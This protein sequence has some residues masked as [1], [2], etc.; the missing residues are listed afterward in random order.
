M[1]D[2]GSLGRLWWRWVPGLKMFR[3]ALS[4][5]RWQRVVSPPSST[6]PQLRLQFHVNV[7]PLGDQA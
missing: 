7:Q 5:P 3:L 6:Q 2:A 4:P 1:R